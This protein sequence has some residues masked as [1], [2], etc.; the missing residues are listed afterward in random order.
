[1]KINNE[2]IQFKFNFD[3]KKEWHNDKI[4]NLKKKYLEFLK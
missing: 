2:K 3:R 4:N 1:M